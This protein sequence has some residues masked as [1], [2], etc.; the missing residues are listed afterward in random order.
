VTLLNGKF[1]LSILGEKAPLLAHFVCGAGLGGFFERKVLLQGNVIGS[2]T[3]TN[4]ELEKGVKEAK[5]EFNKGTKAGEALIKCYWTLEGI[6]AALMEAVITGAG[7]ET[8]E[9]A[10]LSAVA[11]LLAKLEVKLE[12]K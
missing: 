8:S 12:H 5:I 11:D 9:E 2:F 7:M 10:S 1:G 3:Q 6:K 4:A